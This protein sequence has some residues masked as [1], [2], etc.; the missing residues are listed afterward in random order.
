MT[1][2]PERGGET[3]DP[4]T[5]DHCRDR[6][7]RGRAS[8][9]ADC[10]CGHHESEH[11]QYCATIMGDGDGCS[12][13]RDLWTDLA[14]AREE[15]A[16]WESLHVAEIEL[17]GLV[18]SHMDTARGQW[19][20]VD[21]LAQ[22]RAE[23]DDLVAKAWDAARAGIDQLTQ[24]R[25]QARATQENL[26]AELG[27]REQLLADAEQDLRGYQSRL[28]AAQADLGLAQSE[29]DTYRDRCVRM[30]QEITRLDADLA[31]ARAGAS[32]EDVK[33]VRSQ[34][35]AFVNS[36]VSPKSRAAATEGWNAGWSAR[37][38]Q[39]VTL[40]ADL[41]QARQDRD[42]A[43]HD[44]ETLQAIVKRQE[45]E[46]AQARAETD[47]L[48]AKAW[49]A[50]K[51][52]FDELRAEVKRLRTEYT[53]AAADVKQLEAENERL[54]AVVDTVRLVLAND[55]LTSGARYSLERPLAALDGQAQ[56]VPI[57]AE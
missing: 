47:E 57:D 52:G 50:A 27:D 41:A 45:A 35:L 5:C 2:S 3:H 14:Q 20:C 49:D 15:L 10:T 29:R 39:I 31:Q 32:V 36:F 1:S 28:D 33:P 11:V 40:Q 55:V 17:R 44:V 26:L 23:T 56:E 43:D 24:E 37:N 12:C 54:R 30:A 13:S 51:A 19:E 18:E 6:T 46:L 21:Q 7:E 42:D 22:A 53:Y 25:D 4:L 48:V 34:F 9:N 38:F 8:I 16:E